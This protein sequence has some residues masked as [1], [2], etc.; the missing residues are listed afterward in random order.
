MKSSRSEQTNRKIINAALRLFVRKGYH[1]TSIS[2][3]ANLTKLTKGAIY[4]HFKNKDALLSRILEEYERSYVSKMIEQVGSADGNALDKMKHLLRFSFNFAAKNRELCICLTNLS[5]ELYSSSKKYQK[6]IRKPYEELYGLF[7][8][9]LEE[10]VKDGS[11]REDNAPPLVAMN[12]V[13][14]NDGNLL[15]WSLN[16][17]Q[18]NGKNFSRSYMKF[19]LHAIQRHD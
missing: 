14:A 5:T 3:I 17:S 10:G 9:L 18:Y 8:K 13:G 16:M 15:Q 6:G 12:I 1:G 2:D 11:F 4:F 7:T 19:L